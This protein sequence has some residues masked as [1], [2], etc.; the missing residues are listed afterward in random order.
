MGNIRFT[1]PTMSEGEERARELLQKA[2]RLQMSGHMNE[3]FAA[4]NDSIKTY[5]TA[6]GYTFRGWAYSF[7]G[8]YRR[9]IEDCEQAIAIDPDF[10]NPHNDIAAYLIQLDELDQAIPYLERAKKAKRYATPHFPHYN[11]ARIL[12]R[13]GLWFEALAE[14][15]KSLALSPGYTLAKDAYYRLQATMN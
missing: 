13:R 8:K 9:A 14:Y 12:E 5:P 15:K 1:I 3:A 4:Y 6:E 10:G 7:M 11:H 2:Y